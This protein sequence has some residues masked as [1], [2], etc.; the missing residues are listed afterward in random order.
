MQEVIIATKNAGK[1]R[2]FERMFRPLGYEVKTLLDFPDLEDIEETGSIFEENAILKAEGISKVLN[3][4]VIADDSGLSID[5]LNGRPGIYSARYAGEAKNDEAN[6]IKV[7]EELND[8]QDKDRQARFYC[9]LAVAAPEQET[10]TVSGTVEG[11]ILREKRGTHGFGYDPIFFVTEKGKAMAE[12]Q[13]E[14]KAKL[15]HRAQAL[16]KL[17]SMLPSLLDGEKNA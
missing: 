17:E 9:A 8:V 4:I 16:K 7:L 15:S 6:M 11:V 13:P 2:E 3:R 10:F 14:E 5:A 12:L 1:A